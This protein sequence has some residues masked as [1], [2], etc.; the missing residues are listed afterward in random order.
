MP[1]EANYPI[2]SVENS[3][4]IIQVLQESNGARIRDL[5]R[6]LDMSKSAIHNHLSTLRANEY[7]NKEGETYRLG[8]KFLDHGGYVRDN[9]KLYT[10]GKSE[11][12]RLAE[13]T[14]A[15]ASLLTEEYGKG[16]TLYNSSGENAVN[17]P[18]R[19]GRRIH[20]HNIGL[21]KAVLAHLPESRIW[22]IIERHGL[23]KTTENTIT[24]PEELF[25][26]VKRIRE[27]GYS[28]DIEER[29]MG[30]Q[31]IA[32]PIR[33]EEKVVGAIS[34]SFPAGKIDNGFN[35]E[36]KEAVQRASNQVGLE[37]KYS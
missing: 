35:E 6:E 19:T 24:T 25:E 9:L 10:A 17:L 3:L 30:L 33:Q 32:A 23:P 31:C 28:L 4:D 1:K 37:I 7:V 29:E 14:G 15:S 5:E 20:L 21:G 11:V 27:Q 18:I 8:L 13:E 12:D 34:A 26:E 22:E 36:T 2:R 16:V